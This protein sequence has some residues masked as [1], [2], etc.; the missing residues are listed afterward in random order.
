M[1]TSGLFRRP[2]LLRCSVRRYPRPHLT[3]GPGHCQAHPQSPPDLTCGARASA[4]QHRRAPLR[5]FLPGIGSRPRRLRSSRQLLWTLLEA[6][7]CLRFFS[8]FLRSECHFGKPTTSVLE[9][10]HS[11]HNTVLAINN[12]IAPVSP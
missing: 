2:P 8:S 3:A 9:R 7:D 5:L 1:R 6:S 11:A 10:Q 12:I 4:Y